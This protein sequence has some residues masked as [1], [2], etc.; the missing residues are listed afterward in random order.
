MMYLNL[1]SFVIWTLLLSSV[2]ASYNY[3]NQSELD[4]DGLLEVAYLKTDL[5][6]K[7][8]LILILGDG[9]RS[10]L[11]TILRQGTTVNDEAAGND[12]EA[13]FPSIDVD[14]ESGS[15]IIDCLDLE[16]IKQPLKSS[17]FGHLG[18]VC[19]GP[20]VWTRRQLGVGSEKRSA[21]EQGTQQV[22]AV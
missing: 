15:W 8:N 6:D 10:K 12:D 4:I 11:S 1:V 7:N 19:G 14:H 5:R 22:I 21:G 13:I 18:P 3:E 20:T 17:N 16:K 9:R 2:A